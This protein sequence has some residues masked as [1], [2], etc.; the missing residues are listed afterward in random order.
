MKFFISILVAGFLLLAAAWGGLVYYSSAPGPLKET[1][2]ILIEPGDGF[3]EIASLLAK[4]KI[5]S[6]PLLFKAWVIAHNQ[7]HA[8]KAG[9]FEI[10]E[11]ATP[12]DIIDALVS[13]KSIQHSV[14]VPEGLVSKDI[15]SI[16]S[17][18]KL[19]TGETPVTLPE[20]TLL[21]ETYYF[22]R[23]TKRTE[24][25]KRM[26]DAMRKMVD[27]A[28]EK[29]QPDL[30][31]STKQEAIILASIVEK[32]TGVA[33]E[34]P[35]VAA[36][37]INRMR[38]GMPMQSDPTTI[39]GI[40]AATGEMKQ[41]LTTRD[42]EQK[43]PYNT[44]VIGSLPPGP[45]CHPGTDSIEA[46]LNPAKTKELYFVADGKGGHVFAETLEEH[47]NNVLKYRAFL[48]EQ[49]QRATQPR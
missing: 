40:Y 30:P 7:H 10:E 17:E 33:T 37:F 49:R 6:F 31:F 22:L 9:E 12:Q 21:P 15:L 25:I 47:N 36:V 26:Q 43:T 28:W 2:T 45:I 5:V 48:R 1:T 3:D 29:R 27:T 41:S 46:V 38:I 32:E 19:L 39:Y 24:M 23:N 20:G 13:G 11:G 18:T 8:F 44:Y 34:R 16:L 35:R 4:E 42:L 14:T